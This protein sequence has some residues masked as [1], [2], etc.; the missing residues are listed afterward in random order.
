M[1]VDLEGGVLRTG[2][3]LFET[4]PFSTDIGTER[5]WVPASIR[6]AAVQLLTEPS[7]D[8]LVSPS[9]H[10]EDVVGKCRIYFFT[11]RVPYLF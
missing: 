11:D 3:S 1:H 7:M 10:V 6:N 2:D 5:T 8:I 4:F 9:S